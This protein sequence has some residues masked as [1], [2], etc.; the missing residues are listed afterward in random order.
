VLVRGH[1]VKACV[2]IKLSNAP[3]VSKGFYQSVADLKCKNNFVV[4]TADIDYKTKE[5]VRI[6]GIATFIKKYLKAL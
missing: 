3:V 6:V 4:C 1:I 5:G 2:E